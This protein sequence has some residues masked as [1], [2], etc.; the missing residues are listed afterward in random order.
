MKTELIQI[1]NLHR[2]HNIKLHHDSQVT[3]RKV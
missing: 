2:K 1:L 3:S